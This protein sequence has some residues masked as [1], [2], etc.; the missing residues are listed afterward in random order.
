MVHLNNQ[1]NRLSSFGLCF[2]T[3]TV[4]LSGSNDDSEACT[5]DGLNRIANDKKVTIRKCFWELKINQIL[6]RA[7]FK[8]IIIPNH[9]PTFSAYYINC[10]KETQNYTVC[11][12]SRIITEPANGFL[13]NL[14][15]KTLRS[16]FIPAKTQI[17]RQCNFWVGNYTT[18]PSS[19]RKIMK[20]IQCDKANSACS[21]KF[22]VGN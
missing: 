20:Q 15:V 9:K 3:E 19:C 21:F 8:Q 6:V 13:K 11:L 22:N 16:T 18:R 5:P 1:G 17:W 7:V 4:W 12:S 10:N 2:I 14:G